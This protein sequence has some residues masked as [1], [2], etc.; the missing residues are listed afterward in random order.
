[1]ARH[2]TMPEF[3]SEW[4]GFP[5]GAQAVPLVDIVSLV[6]AATSLAESVSH[7]APTGIHDLTT[8][9]KELAPPATPVGDG[10]NGD[11]APS[12]AGSPF[13]NVA[14]GPLDDIDVLVD[15]AT[16]LA[17]PG[18]HAAPEN[19]D[20]LIDAAT[21]LAPPD[22]PAGDGADDLVLTEAGVPLG[23]SAEHAMDSVAQ[24]ADTAAELKMTLVD[25][26]VFLI[27]VGI[28]NLPDAALGLI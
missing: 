1:M 18:T 7:A 22:T 21:G 15:I 10:A 24:A 20:D 27:T 23:A 16:H 4:P 12:D 11:A 17:T 14:E 26:E 13:V 9:A 8:V 28:S 19:I 25:G 6:E 3:A 5:D 2:Q